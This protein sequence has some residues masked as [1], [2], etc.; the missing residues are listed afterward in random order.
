MVDVRRA[1]PEC[2]AQVQRID[3]IS[4]ALGC[5]NPGWAIRVVHSRHL[6][7]QT[8]GSLLNGLRLQPNRMVS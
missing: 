8:S 4:I 1:E 2:I 3:T 6:R 5:I 7:N